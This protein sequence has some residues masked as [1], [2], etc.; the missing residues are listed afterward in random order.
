V[1]HRN[2]ESL[3]KMLGRSTAGLHLYEAHVGGGF[4]I[5]GEIYPEDVL[6]LIAAMRLARPVKWIEDRREHLMAANQSR[7][8]RHRIRAALDHE[9]HLLAI[10]DDFVHDQGAYLRTHGTRVVDTTCGIL[11]GPYRLPH[12]R[13]N[14]HVRLTNKTP[15]AT[16]RAPGRFETNFVRER[17]MDAAAAKLGISRIEVRRRNL[18]A[19]S[20]MPYKRPLV[21]LGDDVELDSGDYARLLDKALAR[22][23]WTALE[24]QA[25]QRRVKGEFVGLGLALYVEKSGLGPTDGARVNIDTSGAIEVITGGASVGQGFETV[26][27]QVCADILGSDYRK[28]RVV[29]GRTDRIEYGI[30]AHATRATVMTAN[31]AAVAAQNARAKALDMAAQLLQAAPSDLDIA[32]GEIAHHLRPVSS[33]RGNRDPG[34][35]ADGWF[36]VAHMTYPYGVQIAMVNIDAATGAVEIEKMLIAYDIGRAINPMLV[37]GQ[38]VGGFAQGL[39]GTL[40]EEFRY[41]ERGQPLSVT[42]ADYLIPTAREVPP[43]DVLLTEDAPT[44]TNPLG[45]K[46]A[47]EG[48]IAA[49]GAVLASAIDDALQMPGAVTTLPVTP[50]TLRSL[51]RRVRG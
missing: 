41:D 34:L 3:A 40:L 47:G 14:G 15:C 1:P 27:A 51:V 35:I 9:A 48:G 33:T 43:V 21:A 49:V 5:R 8:Q 16:Y 23:N 19:A 46:G 44:A 17:L 2:R 50:Q 45:I 25:A 42:L 22:A 26:I 4:G 10:D 31:A 13:V 11:P 20:E 32:L 29:H 38:L 24:Q 28:V 7:Q 37:E 36:S 6:V 39:G 30:G 12:Y 18:I